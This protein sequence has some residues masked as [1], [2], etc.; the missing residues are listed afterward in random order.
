LK[1][2]SAHFV[3][4]SF[5]GPVIFELWSHR[6]D[7][8]RSITLINTFASNPIKGMFGLDIIE[9][10]YHQI[11]SQYERQPELWQS[12]WRSCVYNPVSMRLAALAGGFNLKL[13]H[14]KDIEIYA[15]G[16]AHMELDS[17]LEL[18]D[19]LM[20]F[21]GSSILPTIT[22]PTLVVAGENDRITPL[23]F[24][25]KIHEAIPGSE[26]L[27]IPYGSHCSQ[28]D[29]PDYLNLKLSAFISQVEQSIGG[30]S[31]PAPRR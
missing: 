11:R 4:H 22:V 23:P 13:T 30:G 3:G 27:E 1:V 8:L 20:K 25:R 14:F 12:L 31:S 19:S 29:F 10:L 28:L 2:P 15:R 16:V 24:Q 18:F 6:P 21:D 26:W 17:F 7:L 9:P 5:G